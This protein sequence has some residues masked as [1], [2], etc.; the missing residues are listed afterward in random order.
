MPLAHPLPT[1]RCPRPPLALA[2]VLLALFVMVV[3]GACAGGI[4]VAR[5]AGADLAADELDQVLADLPGGRAGLTMPTEL[6]AVPAD[7]NNPLTAAK[8]ELGE[9]L[10]HDTALAVAGMDATLAHTYSCAS[11][12]QVAAGFKAGIDQGIG[13]GGE[14]FDVAR[15]LID[16]FGD[17]DVQPFA[18]PT[19]LNTAFQDVMLWNGQFGNGAGSVN[20]SVADERLM[21]DE[22]PKATNLLGYEGLETQA[23]AGLGVHRLTGEA[24]DALLSAGYQRLFAAAFPGEFPDPATGDAPVSPTDEQLG[25]AIAAYER[26][27]LATEA[28]FQRWLRGDD[29][30]MSATELRGAL[31]FFGSAGCAECHVGPALSSPTDS[32]HASE[33]FQ[34]VGFADLDDG[35]REG[36]AFLG[37][38]TDADRLGRGGLTGEAS[39]AYTFKVPTL[40]NLADADAYGHGASFDTIAEVVD[41]FLDAVPQNPAAADVLDPRFEPRT[42]TSRERSD[43]LAFLTTAL[44]DPALDRYVPEGWP[45][46][47]VTPR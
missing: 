7:P 21:T 47:E 25:L 29:D 17:P 42:L 36:P 13:E 43:L 40:Y 33:L 11:C 27:V 37:A 23:I 28:P 19:I 34:A 35:D 2:P 41:Y 3:A 14:G 22:T 26:T 16:G 4:D 15:A 6:E 9:V 8:V 32:P 45:D 30:A 38:I 31:V 1:R 18:S 5:T 12:H 46:V 10:F 39:D 44:H 24:N 20:S